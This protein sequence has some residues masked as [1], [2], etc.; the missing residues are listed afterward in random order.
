VI[1]KR[2]GALVIAVVLIVGALAVR[3]RLDKKEDLE[4][5][6]LRVV[7]ATE[8]GVACQ[9]LSK[10]G[11]EVTTEDAQETARTLAKADR[12]SVKTELWLTVEPAAALVDTD[13]A[14][15][16]VKPLLT[17][18]SVTPV[19]TTDLALVIW[20][21]RAAVL[22][23]A[24]PTV[25]LTVRCVGEVAGRDAWSASGGRPEWGQV[26]VA[27]PDPE[28]TAAGLLAL[29]AGAQSWF[30]SAD[31]GSND[32]D[33]DPGFGDWLAGLARATPRGGSLARMLANRAEFDLA[34]APRA[35]ADEQK[36]LADVSVLA[37]EPSTQVRAVAVV[38]PG[39]RGSPKD[40]E[41]AVKWTAAAVKGTPLAADVLEA[42]RLRWRDLS[43]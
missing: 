32:F 29:G 36:G 33:A 43:R 13:R 22:R 38:L 42:L 12:G 1:V 9:R 26:R 15:R 37:L 11:F 16:G 19:A 6:P 40:L 8:L 34:I 3:G 30:K 24:C 4:G 39:S 23:K 17:R 31:V 18:E 25:T 2:F 14:L 27:L 28:L 35:L 41:G 20:K 10:L 5:S 7:C 21:D